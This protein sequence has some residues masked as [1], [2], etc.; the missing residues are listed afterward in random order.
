MT[1]IKNVETRLN[2]MN[3]KHITAIIMASGFSTRMGAQNKLLLPFAEHT[4]L[5]HTLETLLQTPSIRETIAVVR[6]DEVASLCT[7]KVDKII[8]N[9]EAQEGI[10]A[11][12][13]LG[14]QSA[15]GDYY[16]FL[17]GDQPFLKADHLE[18]ICQCAQKGKII[19]PCADD[20]PKGPCL[21]SDEFKNDLMLLQGSHGGKQIIINN[22]SS[23]IYTKISPSEALDDIDTQENYKRLRKKSKKI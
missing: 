23:I 22:Q 7:G 16:L 18:Q 17:P 2:K 6:I 8:F 14:V 20:M 4:L 15:T 5:E 3:Q 12:I 21:F 19:V 11:S 1:V 10:S 9:Q 13:R